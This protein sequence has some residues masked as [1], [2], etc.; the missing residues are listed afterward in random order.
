MKITPQTKIALG[1]PRGK[2]GFD[3]VW[4]MRLLKMFSAYPANYLPIG[5]C[6]P[7][8]S[9]RNQIVHD[10]L[11]S[12]AEYL[13]W[14]DSD[15]VWEPDDIQVLA[16]EDK[17]I[18]TGI[19][20]STSE[21]RMPLI[22]KLDEKNWTATPIVDYPMDRIFE[23]D[24]CGFGFCLTHRRVYE[25]LKE[26]WFEFRSGFSEDLTFCFK[27]KNAG[28]KIWAHPKVQLGHITSRVLTYKDFTD[29]PK[30]MMRVYA[31]KAAYDTAK[32]LEQ[33]HPNWKEDLSLEGVVNQQDEPEKELPPNINTK[34]HWDEVYSKEGSVDET[35]RNYPGK[36][37]FISKELLSGL[38][39]DAK[40]LELGSGMGVLLKIIQKDYP[41]F[42]LTGMDISDVA[43]C[44]LR[45]LGI[46]AEQGK[47]PDW[48][49]GINK[50]LG[51]N[52]NTFDCVIAT[53]L[54]EHLDNVPRFETVVEV[55]RILKP[56]G[57]AIFTVPDNIMPPS[58]E[59]EHRVCY[60]RDRFEEFVRQVFPISK[61][62]SKKCLVSDKPCPG[63]GRWG[64]AP[65]LFGVCKK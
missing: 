42:D 18:I 38:P 31:Q 13:L 26:E 3:W 50:N 11:Q 2:C 40:V 46:N 49:L 27:A 37:P 55:E 12:E 41:K 9:A 19:Q 58:E 34:E 23:V 54:L 21:H 28:F 51:V 47:M 35:W 25:A 53:E 48:T 20:Y 10:F 61:V 52:E 36:F 32:W 7:H 22:R 16:S 59:R 30:S 14:I 24:G 33:C 44:S 57:M 60:T 6:A 43:V 39:E 62:Y 17:D 4:I 64:E 63:G 65:F 5:K 8:A 56:G 29:N 1:L 45:A 15:T